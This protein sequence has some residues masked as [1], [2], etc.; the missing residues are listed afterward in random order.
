MPK[1][2]AEKQTLERISGII[3]STQKM[4]DKLKTG[5]TAGEPSKDLVKL[6]SEA[7]IAIT[8]VERLL[9]DGAPKA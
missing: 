2:R 7:A 1:H 6:A 4:L 8:V 5:L 9:T 3:D